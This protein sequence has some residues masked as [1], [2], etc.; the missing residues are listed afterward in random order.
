M[1]RECI[2]Y[3]DNLAI[4]MKR[5]KKLFPDDIVFSPKQIAKILNCSVAT[6]YRKGYHGGMTC[7]DIA[8]VL[9][10]N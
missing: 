2:N 10:L 5:A 8:R 7:A 3:R 4:V 1:P 9:C 6:I